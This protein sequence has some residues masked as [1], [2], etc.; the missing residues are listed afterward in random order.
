MPTMKT[1]HTP[2]CSK[3][4]QD[5]QACWLGTHS[6]IH[7]TATALPCITR[8]P[9]AGQGGLWGTHYPPL[10]GVSF[11]REQRLWGGNRVLGRVLRDVGHQPPFKN[12][13][14]WFWFSLPLCGL[15]RDKVHPRGRSTMRAT[16]IAA[17]AAATIMVLCSVEGT[18]ATMIP[19]FLP[20]TSMPTPADPFIFLHLV[21]SSRPRYP[22]TPAPPPAQ[23]NLHP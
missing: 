16:A 3:H 15:D 8:E 12:H 22:N 14:C 18:A 13:P 10:A 20:Q 4:Q 2:C 21:R 7:R 23:P 17:L 11:W 19:P 1:P 6:H 5:A 9:E